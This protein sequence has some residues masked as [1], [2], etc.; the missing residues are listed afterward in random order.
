LQIKI[1]GNLDA[2]YHFDIKD[3]V[4]FFFSSIVLV[5]IVKVAIVSTVRVPIAAAVTV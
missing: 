2:L 4:K 3:I 5:V 1:F